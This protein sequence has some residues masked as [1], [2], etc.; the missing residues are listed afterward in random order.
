MGFHYILN[1]PRILKRELRV[2]E[3]ICS[4]YRSC[5]ETWIIRN[6]YIFELD[7]S[8][9]MGTRTIIIIQY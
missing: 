1:P 8:T 7:I 2:F 6:I 4:R 3:Y 9:G 5:E